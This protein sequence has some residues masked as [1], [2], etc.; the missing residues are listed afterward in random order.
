M[1]LG[2][3]RAHVVYGVISEMTKTNVI[4]SKIARINGREKFVLSRKH[5]ISVLMRV[6]PQWTVWFNW[7]GSF[8]NV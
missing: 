1:A 5:P 8:F 4:G 2:C 6:M 7:N 3:A